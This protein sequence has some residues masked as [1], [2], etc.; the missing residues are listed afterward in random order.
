V[1]LAAFAPSVHA[2]DTATFFKQ[3]CVAC[4]TIGGGPL[5]GPDLKGVTERQDREWMIRFIQ[6]PQ[7]VLDSGDE[8]AQQILEESNGIVMPALPGVTPDM[9]AALLD[10]IE[11]E[12]KLERSQFGGFSFDDGPFTAEDVANGRKI[13][14]GTTRLQN[15]GTACNACHTVR[16]LGGLGGGR[17]GPDQTMVYDTLGGKKSLSAWLSGPATPMMKAVY[18]DHPLEPEEIRPLV[19]FFEDVASQ[20]KNNFSLTPVYFF[21]IACTGSGLSLFA[22]GA[23]WKNRFRA[24]R[25]PMVAESATRNRA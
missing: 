16:G 5:V 12:S 8:Y 4:H 25:R 11:A 10:L 6:N 13:F 17:L 14:L 1:F 18:D 22:F 2:Q 20:G 23:I 21:L 9:A 3:N 24:V 19:A 15:G 7:A